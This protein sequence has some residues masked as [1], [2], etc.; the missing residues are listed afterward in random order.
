[1]KLVI[2]IIILLSACQSKSIQ[3]EDME[4]YIMDEFAFALG[5]SK[6]KMEDLKDADF[7]KHKR[8]INQQFS[9]ESIPKDLSYSSIILKKP[10]IKIVYSYGS[11]EDYSKNGKYFEK[12]FIIYADNKESFTAR[13]LI[14]KI[15]NATLKDLKN[16][17]HYFFEGMNFI[18]YENNIPVYQLM[19]G[20]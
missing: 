15:N 12:T 19:Q 1:M 17:P 10:A 3:K 4:E 14:V 2:L 8:L 7:E 11:Y 18:G 16:D 5:S 20:S 13:E 9:D 6:M